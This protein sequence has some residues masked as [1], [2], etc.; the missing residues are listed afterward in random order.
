LAS[1]SDP[2]KDGF[3]HLAYPFPIF[4]GGSRKFG[5]NCWPSH[6]WLAVVSK[7]SNTSEIKTAL[8]LGSIHGSPLFPANLVQF[9]PLISEKR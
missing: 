9:G 5:L 1:I 8:G 2:V 7:R 6:F 3:G 4:T